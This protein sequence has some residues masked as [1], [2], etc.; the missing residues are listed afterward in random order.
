L[1]DAQSE[2]NR[3]VAHHKGGKLLKGFTHDFSPVKDIFHLTDE[4]GRVHTVK[5]SD[6][7]AIFFVKTFKGRKEYVEKNR[8]NQVDPASLKGMKIKVEFADGEIVRGMSL[9]YSK[10][11]KGF[12]MA[13][14]DPDSN[15]ERIYV[16]AENAR[17]VE[18]G[19][20]AEK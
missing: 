6:L 16:V 11:R 9:A 19:S 12:Y 15:N 3:I 8:F 2:R 14:I 20:A 7:K 10:Q 13:P 5:C 17:K 4:L 18:L 1:T